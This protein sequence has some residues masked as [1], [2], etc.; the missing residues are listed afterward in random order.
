M[1]GVDIEM[2]GNK[3][4]LRLL[5][6]ELRALRSHYN[7]TSHSDCQKTIL[8][9]VAYTPTP[10]DLDKP[11]YFTKIYMLREHGARTITDKLEKGKA[12]P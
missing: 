1:K 7:I 5:Y 9:T 3:G 6:H 2:E 11:V 4:N 10:E 8:S 12:N